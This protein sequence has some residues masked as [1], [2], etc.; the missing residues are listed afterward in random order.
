MHINLEHKEQILL[1]KNPNP[2]KRNFE[3]GSRLSA[4]VPNA[5]GNTTTHLSHGDGF[6]ELRVEWDHIG[7]KGSLKKLEFLNLY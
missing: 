7:Y 4:G 5:D 2:S 1:W 6:L 3:W